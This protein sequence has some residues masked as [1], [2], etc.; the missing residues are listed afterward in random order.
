ML[1]LVTGA[2][3]F[4]A[5]QLIPRLLERGHQVRALA[6]DPRRLDGK[7]WAG[8]TDIVHGDV[9]RPETL[10]RALQGVHTA[11]YLIHSMACGD[12]YASCDLAGARNFAQAA[13][14]AGVRHIVYLGGLANPDE[15]IGPY[16]RSRAETGAALRHGSVPVTEFRASVIA[17]PGSTSFEMIRRVTELFPVIPGPTW[18]RHRAQPIAA[19]NVVDYL[20]GALENTEAQG[21][22]FEIGG[23]EV[24][25]YDELMLRYAR[26]RGLKRRTVLIPGLPVWLMALG[27]RLLTPVPQATAAA[28]V[29]ELRIDSVVVHGA[30]LRAFPEVKLIDFASAARASLDR[31]QPTRVARAQEVR[32][33]L[34]TSVER[35]LNA[36]AAKTKLLGHWRFASATRA[37]FIQLAVA[38]LAMFLLSHA[39]LVAATEHHGTAATISDVCGARPGQPFRSMAELRSIMESLG[40]RVIRISTDAGC[41]S[42]R[43]VNRGGKPFDVQFP[44]ADLRSVSR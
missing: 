13:A 6:R 35:G 3:G 4:M 1:I 8:A 30:A 15:Q 37:S 41:Y 19:G 9:L 27:F 11:Y 29:G 40:Y 28:L 31:L 38:S 26:V 20:L 17:G 32:T 33:R 39:G 16:M 7:A 34:L 21:Q 14:D 5:G 36:I 43:L 24:L 22:V 44:G 23:P 42:L 12:S 10:P 25:T 18:M 2:T